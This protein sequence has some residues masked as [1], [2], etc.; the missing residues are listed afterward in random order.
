[1]RQRPSFAGA[2][3]EVS[4]LARSIAFH[5]LWLPTLGFHRVWEGPSSVLWARGYDQLVMRQAKEGVSYGPGALSLA[6][7]ASRIARASGKSESGSL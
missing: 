4:D 1:M 6:V 7:C 3:I 2:A 5:R